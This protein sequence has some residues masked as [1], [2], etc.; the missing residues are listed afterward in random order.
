MV[1]FNGYPQHKN[2]YLSVDYQKIDSKKVI[3][4]STFNDKIIPYEFLLTEYCK[5]KT[6]N[7]NTYLYLKNG[8]HSF[9]AYGQNEAK[10]CFEILD[11][12]ITCAEKKPI[13]AFIVDD[14]VVEFYPYR[15]NIYKK[16]DYGYD[17]YLANQEQSKLYKRN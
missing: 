14:N 16:Y 11:S 17:Y 1:I 7:S 5:Q 10:I 2:F 3:F 13:Q 12:K 8:D 9:A 6:S 15:K 4:F